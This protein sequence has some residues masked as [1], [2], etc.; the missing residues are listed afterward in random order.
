MSET[1]NPGEQGRPDETQRQYTL[2][3]VEAVAASYGDS[4]LDQDT[5]QGS[6]R[7]LGQLPLRLGRR[8]RL[9]DGDGIREGRVVEVEE[10]GAT[11]EFDGEEGHTRFGTDRI[12]AARD[13]AVEHRKEGAVV[14]GVVSVSLAGLYAIIKH[15]S[16]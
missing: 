11:V 5:E 7:R 14:A 9:V 2:E 13:Y 16:K 10:D 1:S 15:R 12:Y 3:E 4:L 6:W 8:F